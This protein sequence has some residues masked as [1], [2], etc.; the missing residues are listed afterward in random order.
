[1]GKRSDFNELAKHLFILVVLSLAFFPLFVMLANSGKD[2][3]QF[4]ANRFSFMLPFHFENY[5]TAW[6]LSLIHI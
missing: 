3:A 2:G 6:G 1:M 4:A 5:A